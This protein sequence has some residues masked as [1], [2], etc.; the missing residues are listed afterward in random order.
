MSALGAWNHGQDQVVDERPVGD[1]PPPSKEQTTR[2]LG[3]PATLQGPSDRFTF[4]RVR[5]GSNV[6]VAYDPCRPI[7]IVVN[8]RTA[9]AEADVLLGQSLEIINNATGLQFKID[10]ETTEPPDAQRAP[11]QPDRYPGR[12]APVLVAWS[13]PQEYPGI[14]GDVAG[15]G[16]SHPLPVATI[17]ST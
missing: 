15:V 1:R 17:A 10:R 3:R 8:K 6:P 11:Y 13:D 2:P 9:P 7:H 12:W 4:M 16:G 5:P 14:T